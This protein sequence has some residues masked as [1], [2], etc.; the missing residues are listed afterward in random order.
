L[1]AADLVSLLMRPIPTPIRECS[2]DQQGANPRPGHVP[3]AAQPHAA[4]AYPKS[5]GGGHDVSLIFAESERPEP[6]PDHRLTLRSF[7]GRGSLR[8]GMRA[9]VRSLRLT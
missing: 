3:G 8:L 9:T 2:I 4:T 1:A 7:G 5:T 6:R